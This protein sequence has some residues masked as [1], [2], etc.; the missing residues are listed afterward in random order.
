MLKT[1]YFED[2]RKKNEQKRKL[3]STL[4][5]IILLTFIILFIYIG[6]FFYQLQNFGYFVKAVEDSSLVEYT[7]NNH[8]LY[9]VCP[10]SNIQTGASLSYDEHQLKTLFK[11]KCDVCINTDNRTVSNTT[12]TNE[13]KIMMSHQGFTINDIRYMFRCAL[14]HA[15]ISEKEYK[16][17]IK[18]I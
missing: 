12:L 17:Y 6:Q 2:K 10:T 1:L 7:C 11:E 3:I 18:K 16:E 15:F 5:N 8:I 9:E 13:I 4:N 14:K